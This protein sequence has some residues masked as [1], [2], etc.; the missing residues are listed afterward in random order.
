MSELRGPDYKLLDSVGTGT[1]AEI[2]K[3]VC[4][5]AQKV[6]PG[7][8]MEEAMKFARHAAEIADE[9]EH[10]IEM[11]SKYKGKNVSKWK[12]NKERL[13]ANIEKWKRQGERYSFLKPAGKNYAGAKVYTGAT[14]RAKQFMKDESDCKEGSYHEMFW[15]LRDDKNRPHFFQGEILKAM[16]REMESAGDFDEMSAGERKEKIAKVW[17]TGR[18]GKEKRG[19]FD[20]IYFDQF[21]TQAVWYAIGTQEPQWNDVKDLPIP[22]PKLTEL[23]TKLKAMFKGVQGFV[24]RLQDGSWK[25]GDYDAEADPLVRH[26]VDGGF[27]HDG[28]DSSGEFK[29]AAEWA[30]LMIHL[31]QDVDDPRKKP[32]Y[33][34]RDPQSPNYGA[35]CYAGHIP[36][37]DYEKWRNF[38]LC[39]RGSYAFHQHA[40]SI[41]PYS[42][43]G[44]VRKRASKSRPM[45]G[46]NPIWQAETAVE[47]GLC[48]VDDFGQIAGVKTLET[49][50]AERA[51]RAEQEAEERKA[52]AER[53][54][55]EF[56]KGLDSRKRL[57]L[58]ADNKPAND[59][60]Y[61]YKVNGWGV[62][63]LRSD[64]KALLAEGLIIGDRQAQTI[65]AKKFVVQRVAEKFVRDLQ[66]TLDAYEPWL[67]LT[68]KPAA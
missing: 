63:A 31:A 60:A 5:V 57:L 7:Y 37:S 47:M 43:V 24:R 18:R 50:E 34:D 1:I 4:D 22:E 25:E 67:G 51:Q 36:E 17:D 56:R 59:L 32:L 30:Q 9:R 68:M 64:I 2:A 49:I 6:I 48:R 12:A 58:E 52:E 23:Q 45:F 29:T 66:A 46:C 27:V 41:G 35:Q 28:E 8:S 61:T 19:F 38:P 44:K 42:E 39:V 21:G 54:A 26:L 33:S 20:K 62:D 13:L 40:Q 14:R 53:K 65:T 15:N 55:A 3:T 16:E 10:A 11:L